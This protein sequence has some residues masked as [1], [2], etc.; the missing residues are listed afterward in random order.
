MIELLIAI[1]ILAIIVVP[2]L[3]S[4]ISSA[5]IS[6]KAKQTMKGTTIAENLMEEFIELEVRDAL[7]KYVGSVNTDGLVSI[8]IT[9]AQIGESRAEDFTALVELDPTVY[10]QENAERV[11]DVD[12]ITMSDCAIYSMNQT[13]D[14]NI[15]EQYASWSAEAYAIDPIRYQKKDETFFKENLDRK[16][17]ITLLDKGTTQNKE[18]ETIHLCKV[19]MTIEYEWKGTDRVV[20]EEH[21]K[22]KVT[23]ELFDNAKSKKPLAAVYLMYMPRYEAAKK[24]H[25]DTIIVDNSGNLVTNC[26]L[27]QEK[28]ADDLLNTSYRPDY[29]I[30]EDPKGS[31][32]ADTKAAISFRTNR[33]DAAKKLTC[34]LTYAKKNG[35]SS[36]KGDVAKQVLQACGADGKPLNDTKQQNRIYTIKITVSRAGQPIA[37][38]EGTK[39]D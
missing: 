23:K 27:V 18:H 29:H 12:A 13:Q 3:Q 28:S 6:G 24:G 21:R 25:Q 1:T 26:Y 36:V 19:I 20:R 16:I 34:K 15:Y 32:T 5:R 17:T 37:T 11:I 10:A 33:H 31:I 35:T 39:M 9:A 30:L 8:P 38:L 7:A 2:L 14:D 4:F 22:Q